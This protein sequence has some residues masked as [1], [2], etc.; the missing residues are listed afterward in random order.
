MFI[1]PSSRKVKKKNGLKKN[2]GWTC[3]VHRRRH[4][5][6]QKQY[7]ICFLSTQHMR[8][9]SSQVWCEQEKRK[10]NGKWCTMNSYFTFITNIMCVFHCAKKENRLDLH[11]FTAT[12]VV[13]QTYRHSTLDTFLIT[14]R[15]SIF[16]G[17]EITIEQYIGVMMR[18]P[19]NLANSCFEKKKH[20]VF[21][22]I[23]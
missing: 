13:H 23:R 17:N 16:L 12:G 8:C 2:S 19:S 7:L 15:L 4:G 5:H 10:I 20:C 6:R 22:L 3:N 9:G 1:R 18:F 11:Q 21:L 14:T